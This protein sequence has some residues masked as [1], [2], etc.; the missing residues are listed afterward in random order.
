M[1]VSDTFPGIGVLF[2]LIILL[3]GH[4]L[5]F[6][7]G[8]VSGVV[9]GLRLNLIEFLKYDSKKEGYAFDTFKKK[10]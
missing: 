10:E 4:L 1:Q 3:I 9:H 6:T 8:I 5:N 2:A 7:L